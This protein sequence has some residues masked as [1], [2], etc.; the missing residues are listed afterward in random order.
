M[1]L[2]VFCTWQRWKESLAPVQNVKNEIPSLS[3][4]SG[5]RNTGAAPSNVLKRVRCSHPSRYVAT[6]LV[7][8]TNRYGTPSIA[9]MRGTGCISSMLI[10]KRRTNDEVM[11]KRSAHT[12]LLFKG[13]SSMWG[14]KMKIPRRIIF[15]TLS[16]FFCCFIYH[17]EK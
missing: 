17:I 6:I 5:L 15:Q 9:V 16:S 13:M 12:L 11:S 3:Q 10:R 1:F 2:I 7:F 8:R 14:G 4:R